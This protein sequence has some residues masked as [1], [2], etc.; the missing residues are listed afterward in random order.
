[1]DWNSEK[2]GNVVVLAFFLILTTAGFTYAILA[3]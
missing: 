2:I 3:Y 1:M